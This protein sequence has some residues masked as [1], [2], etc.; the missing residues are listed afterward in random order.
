MVTTAFFLERR[1]AVRPI[2]ILKTIGPK[3]KEKIDTTSGCLLYTSQTTQHRT[4]QENLWLSAETDEKA[5]GCD[6]IHQLFHRFRQIAIGFLA[7]Y[8]AELFEMCIRDS[9]RSC[10]S[11]LSSLAQSF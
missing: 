9:Q 4:G 11:S 2:T 3:K 7:R 1:N 8:G 5:G 10:Q 6:R